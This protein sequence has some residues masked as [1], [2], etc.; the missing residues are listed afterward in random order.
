M[1]LPYIRLS[2]PKEAP[3]VTLFHVWGD[4][5]LARHMTRK[6]DDKW[7]AGLATRWTFLTAWSC[8]ELSCHLALGLDPLDPQQRL[9]PA[10]WKNL[11]RRLEP[12]KLSIDPKQ[13]PWDDLLLIQEE[14][15][16]FAHLGAGGGRFSTAIDA[17]FAVQEAE[18][19]IVRFF[20]LVGVFVPKWLTATG[21]TWPEDN[22]PNEQFGKG[23]G[24]SGT[25]GTIV[26]DSKQGDPTMIRIATKRL[27]GNENVE[28][29]PLGFDWKSRIEEILENL[30]TPV[31]GIRVYDGSKTYLDDDLAMWGI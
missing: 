21:T 24:L 20:Q 30:G 13:A 7:M 23:G 29:Y 17:E 16:P 25:H 27:D 28:L 14:R 31:K 1:R 6:T 11:N 18:K 4:L 5:L 10:F 3:L 15:H 12:R 8:F 2:D 22:N 9:S 26:G 19:A